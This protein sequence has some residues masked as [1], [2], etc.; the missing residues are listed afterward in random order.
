MDI[1]LTKVELRKRHVVVILVAQKKLQL[2]RIELYGLRFGWILGYAVAPRILQ[3]HA[4]TTPYIH[5]YT[6]SSK[7]EQLTVMLGILR[8]TRANRRTLPQTDSLVVCT[9]TPPLTLL[10][11]LSK[12]IIQPYPFYFL[13]PYRSAL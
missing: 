1:V 13:L 7:T 10:A 2:S 8:P 9:F 11:S 5:T 4:C 6:N 12:K 3:H